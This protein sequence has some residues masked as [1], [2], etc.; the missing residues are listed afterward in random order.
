MLVPMPS[1]R[2]SLRRHQRLAGRFQPTEPPR[3]HR[4]RCSR[5]RRRTSGSVH[6][7]HATK[8]GK[9]SALSPTCRPS[10]QH[11]THEDPSYEVCAEEKSQASC[12]KCIPESFKNSK[13][14]AIGVSLIWPT[15]STSSMWQV[16]KTT[17]PREVW[18]GTEHERLHVQ[19]QRVSSRNIANPWSPC[20]PDSQ[21]HHSYRP[22]VPHS[23][24]I[25]Q[26]D[27]R[28]RNTP[29][30]QHCKLHDW[31]VHQQDPITHRLLGSRPSGHH[32]LQGRRQPSWRRNW[33]VRFGA[34]PLGQK[35]SSSFVDWL[36]WIG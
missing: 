11:Y 15:S 18:S 21:E 36:R 33:W 19:E 3:N 6:V 34:L 17:E 31:A 29:S 9:A 1:R 22:A 26:W 16:S 8:E 5:S 14:I 32:Q 10:L 27:I 2:Q 30:I 28:K 25:S 13:A 4:W 20:L 35:R 24:G 23:Q 12:S 7:A